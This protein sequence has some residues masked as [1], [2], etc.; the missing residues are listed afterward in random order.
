MELKTAITERHSIRGYTSEPVKQ[1]TL[2]DVLRL[3]TR[4]VSSVNA[5]P[6]E[7]VV[8]TGSVLDAIREDNV[9][10]MR[11]QL[12]L[13]IP[14]VSLEG[15]YHKRRI[16]VAK[17][18]LIAMEIPRED[19][20]RRDWWLERGYRYFDAPAAIILCMDDS[21][22]EA[23]YRFDMGC[24]AQNI[25]LA[26][27]EFG[28]GTCVEY[29]GVMYQRGLR[30]YLQ[31]PENKRI[32]CAIAIGYPDPEFPANHVVSDR[33]DVENITSWYGFPEETD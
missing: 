3:A 28:L 21:L 22:D 14:A 32:V 29:Q 9:A 16:D 1:E 5:Q 10:C 2:R 8:A 18:L 6:W 13:D 4:A 25:C 7:F 12:P 15:V 26:A 20:A 11:D 31:I 17:Q 19:R 24:V 30:K 33:E 27:K 23:T